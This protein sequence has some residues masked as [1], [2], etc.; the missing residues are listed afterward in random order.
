MN[1]FY[2][3]LIMIILTHLC[4]L[5]NMSDSNSFITAHTSLSDSETPT[6]IVYPPPAPHGDVEQQLPVF[7]DDWKFPS[8]HQH[9]FSFACWFCVG[10]RSLGLLWLAVR[11]ENGWERYLTRTRDSVMQFTTAVSICTINTLYLIYN[12]S[13]FLAGTRPCCGC[14]I[15]DNHTSC[16]ISRLHWFLLLHTC[17][18]FI[19]GLY[20]GTSW[21]ANVFRRQSSIVTTT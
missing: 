18:L 8:Q 4:P 20:T 14:C 12:V 15:Y 17:H 1:L 2:V 11:E 6:T 10:Q 16:S 21:A 13:I 3:G 9:L 19:Y 5:H 7:P